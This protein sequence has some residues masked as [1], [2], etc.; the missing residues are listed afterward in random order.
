MD[1]GEAA[2]GYGRDASREALGLEC[3]GWFQASLG[4][5]RSRTPG[6][7]N[8]VE[9][10]L[11]TRREGAGEEPGVVAG[12]TVEVKDVDVGLWGVWLKGVDMGV[13]EIPWSPGDHRRGIR[14]G[15]IWNDRGARRSCPD[16]GEAQALKEQW[17]RFRERTRAPV[18]GA[19]GEGAGR[20][21]IADGVALTWSGLAERLP[22]ERAW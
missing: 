7:G 17:E 10:R 3:P 11:R 19:S 8:G 22:P 9:S 6:G 16:S 15:W 20:N 4:H 2:L 1:L 5:C 18:S 21:L 13:P 12:L 14:S